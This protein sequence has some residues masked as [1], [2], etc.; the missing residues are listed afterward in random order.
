MSSRS[1][2]RRPPPSGPTGFVK[3]DVERFKLFGDTLASQTEPFTISKREADRRGESFV[4]E[5][6]V[7]ALSRLINQRRQ[8]ISQARTQPGRAATI[9]T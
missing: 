2:N 4:G 7:Q 6:Q 8:Q 5:D 3:E 1:S 9:L